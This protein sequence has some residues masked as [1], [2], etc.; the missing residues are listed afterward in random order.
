MVSLRAYFPYFDYFLPVTTLELQLL[1][2]SK[3]RKNVE[4]LM[5]FGASE[6]NADDTETDIQT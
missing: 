3:I 1:C 5:V 4:L 6:T 2:I